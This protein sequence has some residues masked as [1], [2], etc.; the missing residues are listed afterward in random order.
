MIYRS[1]AVLGM[2]IFYALYF[3]K[4]FSQ[5]KKGIEVYKLAKENGKE[6]LNATEAALKVITIIIP[7]IEVISIVWGRSYLPIMGK[8][9]GF[10]F[11]VFADFTFL[12][13]IISMKDSW[14]VGVAKEDTNRKL[15]T[16]GIYQYSRNPAFLAFDLMYIGLSLMYCSIPMIIVTLIGI[17]MLHLQILKEEKFMTDLKGEE[18]LEYKKTTGRYVGYKEFSFQSVRMIVYFILF[19]WCVFYIVT[20]VFYAGIFLSWIWIWILIGAFAFLRFTMLKMSIDKNKR[21]KIP[22]A[23]KIIYYTVFFLSLAFFLA[24]EFN[25]S[26]AMNTKPQKDLDYVIVLGAGLNGTTPTKPLAKR[27]E[28]GYIYMSDNPD[29]ILIASGGQGFHE[30]ISEAECIKRELVKMGIDEDRI[31]LENRSTSTIE[32]LKFSLE[33]IGDPD[34]EV[35]IITNS[36]HEY[37]AGLIAKNVGYTNAHSV[38]AVTLFPVGIHYML[39]EFFGVVRLWM[40]LKQIVF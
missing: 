26:V 22:K 3:I 14:R 19:V 27:I 17:I 6:K 28:E 32:N 18:Y 1:L 34:A 21:L 29:T 25:I 30:S 38:P 37:R 39:R 31:I 40:E 4:L 20:L 13:A 10:Y 23:I 16:K 8:I 35:G 36:F 5:K 11:L 9:I 7:I 12:F 24:I 33:I 2:A 15:I